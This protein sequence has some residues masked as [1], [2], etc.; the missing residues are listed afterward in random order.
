M[1]IPTQNEFLLLFLQILSDG[2]EVTRGQMLYRLAQRPRIDQNEA[3]LVL[4]EI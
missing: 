3:Q 2:S 4:R 1:P